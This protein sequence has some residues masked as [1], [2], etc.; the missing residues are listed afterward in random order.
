MVAAKGNDY[1]LKRKV[2]PQYTQEQLQAIADDLLDYAEKA[3][4]I[5]LAPWCRKQKKSLSWL[6]ELAKDHEVIKD[7]HK[8]AKELLG[9]K[10]VNSSFYGEGNATVG[11]KYL[12]IYDKD[13]K[14]L[15][16]WQ[17]KIAKASEGDMK[18]TADEFV[19]AIKESSLL[20][21]L[22]QKD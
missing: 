21:L 16:E 8:Q 22:M 5:H 7:A 20:Q 1:T 14:N 19:K 4:S 6:N 10:V 15:L 9:A 13:F 18:A 12:P 11:L 17:A 2:N 3:K